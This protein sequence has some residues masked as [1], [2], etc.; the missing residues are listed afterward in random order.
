MKTFGIVAFAV[1]SLLAIG[2]VVTTGGTPPASEPSTPSGHHYHATPGTAQTATQPAGT[3]ALVPGVG[4][5]A[6]TVA[7]PVATAA[8]PATGSTAPA[9]TTTIPSAKDAG[10]KG[11]VTLSTA[12]PP[13]TTTTPP[14][15]TAS[16]K[17]STPGTSATAPKIVNPKP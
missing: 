12:V 15:T 14:V 5:P 13:Q 1:G 10:N 16:K 8:T 4:G 2:C 6:S 9:S 7:P 3:G 17:N 11:P